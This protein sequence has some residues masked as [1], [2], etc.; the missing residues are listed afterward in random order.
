[1]VIKLTAIFLRAG[2][3][4]HH[5]RLPDQ[6]RRRL[7]LGACRRLARLPLSWRQAGAR[8]MD[9]SYVQTLVDKGEITEEEANVHP[10]SNI[11]MGC[12]G[13]EDDPPSTS[14]SSR[15]LRPAMC[16]WPAATACG[17]T[18]APTSWARCC[19]RCRPREATEFLID[20]ARSARAGRRR[21]PV[22]GDR[23]AGAAGRLIAQPPGA[24]GLL[25]AA[26]RGG[27]ARLRF[28][29]RPCRTGLLKFVLA[30]AQARR[31]QRRAGG[32]RWRPAPGAAG[33]ILSPPRSCRAAAPR[34]RTL[35]DGKAQLAFSAED[36]SQ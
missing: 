31:L 25:A 14:T 22:A 1:M 6:P 10:Q 8:T 2:A 16:C 17:T 9:H 26:W 35:A 27:P 18:S 15:K 28:S 36:R 12:L 30:L 19:R 4:Q 5:G 13:T 7:P 23:Q 29:S 24:A 32:D 34:R 20:K 33:G 3:A 11:L 21:Q